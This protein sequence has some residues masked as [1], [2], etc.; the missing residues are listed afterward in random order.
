MRP[1]APP[2]PPAGLPPERIRRTLDRIARKAPGTHPSE[3]A[4]SLWLSAVAPGRLHAAWHIL[5]SD[6]AA[7]LREVPASHP[8]LVLRVYRLTAGDASSG[9]FDRVVD[10]IE[11]RRTVEVRDET[12]AFGAELGLLR[13]DGRLRRL[14]LAG[15]AA[16]IPV[17][18]SRTAIRRVIDVRRPDARP[19]P[20]PPP[21]EE[22]ARDAMSLLSSGRFP[23]V[24]IRP[25]SMRRHRKP[26]PP[27]VV[28]RNGRRAVAARE[29]PVPHAGAAGTPRPV[30]VLCAYSGAGP[31]SGARAGLGWPLALRT[32]LATGVR[33]RGT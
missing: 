6:L 19:L 5:K 17:T 30:A 9:W 8:P 26:P 23:S 11:G 4:T 1:S 21:A 3:S 22:S 10:G 27:V 7:A 15:P 18:E 33:E 16:A 32:R 24:V 29:S 14:A 2:E 25:L 12:G 31:A 28:P 13:P 20:F